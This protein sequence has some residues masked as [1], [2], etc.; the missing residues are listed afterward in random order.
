M[1]KII[2]VLVVGFLLTNVT[3]SQEA[4]KPTP[5]IHDIED[6]LKNPSFLKGQLVK[7]TFKAFQKINSKNYLVSFETPDYQTH[8]YYLQ[9]GTFK[10]LKAAGYYKIIDGKAQDINFDFADGQ[11]IR[12]TAIVSGTISYQTRLGL[13]ST[14]TK[15]TLVEIEPVN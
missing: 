8:L 14:V 9:K 1:R 10:Q 12:I 7:G 6:L 11:S 2:M 15:L 5:I 3:Y 13:T 4:Q